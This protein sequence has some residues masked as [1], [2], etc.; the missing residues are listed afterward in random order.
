M[1]QYTADNLLT[2]ITT[3]ENPEM[4]TASGNPAALARA[5]GGSRSWIY[6]QPDFLARINIKHPHTRPASTDRT[7][8]SDASWQRRIELATQRI[9][10]N[11]QR[12]AQLAIAHGQHR[13]ERIT[14]SKTLS[15]TQT[16]SS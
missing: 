11:R 9:K 2:I 16:R 12:R 13:A 5:A 8:A 15:I 14:A 10:Q 6:T 7:C 3:L 1:N 4:P